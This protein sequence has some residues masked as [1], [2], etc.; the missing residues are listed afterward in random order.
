MSPDEKAQAMRSVSEV[1]TAIEAVLAGETGEE[2]E[3]AS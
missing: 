3:M 1:V 2:P